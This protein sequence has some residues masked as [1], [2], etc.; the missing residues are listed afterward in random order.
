[1]SSLILIVTLGATWLPLTTGQANGR[2]PVF[3]LAG[4]PLAVSIGKGQ[5]GPVGWFWLAPQA[6]DYDNLAH[7]GH[8]ALPGCHQPI[9]YRLEAL[10][11]LRGRPGFQLSEVPALASPGTHRLV[12]SPDAQAGAW[13]EGEPLPPHLELV[14][15]RD[16]TYPGLLTELIGV[17]FVHWPRPLPGRGHQTDLRLGADCVALVTYGRR[18]LGEPVPYAA[19][20]ALLRWTDEIARADDLV[21]LRAGKPIPVRT[22]DVLHFGFQTAVVSEDTPPLGRLDATD[23]IIHTFHGLA[24][25]V[26]LAD[27]P[28]RAGRVRILRWPVE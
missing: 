16:D 24:E 8:P 4:E 20:A 19:P 25:E 12:A 3:L 28:Y 14:I 5:A 13:P 11:A 7:C 2:G 17:P 22:G 6:G 9:R 23:R 27:L 21:D 1:M 15:R 18:R 26:D 10:P